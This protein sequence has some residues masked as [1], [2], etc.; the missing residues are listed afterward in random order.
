LAIEGA[1]ILVLRILEI[2]IPKVWE[3]KATEMYVSELEAAN[4][5]RFGD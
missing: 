5:L 3:E 2:L 4:S 1:N